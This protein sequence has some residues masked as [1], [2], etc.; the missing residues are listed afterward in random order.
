M[1][2][3]EQRPADSGMG[4]RKWLGRIVA[5]VLLGEAI[6][7][8]IVSAINNIFV[9]W[10]GDLFGQSTQLPASFT[11]RPY[12]Y[13]DFLVSVLESC[14]A[15]IIAVIVNF[16]FLRKRPVKQIPL[17]AMPVETA[18][19]TTESSTPEPV[20]EVMSPI[21]PGEPDAEKRQATELL[22]NAPIIPPAPPL[23]VKAAA[24]IPPVATQA[25]SLMTPPTEVAGSQLPKAEAPSPKK[26]REILYNSV[27]EP[28]PIDEDGN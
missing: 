23:P 15:A 16:I 28:L 7:N 6:W 22:P 26:H 8:L 1:V 10:L 18:P 14:V 20:A 25:A 17:R 3:I 21:V 24:G 13:P 11:Q 27:G 2:A 4:A 5:G 9:P 19:L 12:D